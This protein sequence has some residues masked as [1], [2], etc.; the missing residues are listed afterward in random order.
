MAATI[1]LHW[2]ATS[3]TWVRQGVYHTII[4]GDGRVQRLHAYTLDLPAH[5]YRRNSN[6]VALSCACMGGIPDP[7]TIPPTAPQ[8]ASLCREAADLARSWGWSAG[9][10]TIQRLMT[11]AEAASNRDGRLLHDNYG[12]VIWGGTGERWDLLQLERGGPT[13]GGDQLRQRIRALL[14]GDGDGESGGEGAAQNSAGESPAPPRLR[15]RRAGVMQARG[16]DLA[17]QIDTNGTSWA[18][19]AELLARYD[20][21]YDWDAP[22]RRIL[23]GSTDVAPSYQGDQ[24][25]TSVGWP[26]FEMGLQNGQGQ[27]ILRGILRRGQ[28][29]D[30]GPGEAGEPLRAWCRVLEFAEEFGI[31]ASFEPFSLGERRGG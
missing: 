15:F 31:T 21:P 10:I 30:E 16:R 6:S 1:Y 26:L 23:V 27:V 17:V 14:R 4:A 8:L 22:R 28:T 25:Q 12:P 19:A 2:A 24:V 9:D 5:T 11:H 18:L 29:G 20:I 7:W 13:N 3:Y